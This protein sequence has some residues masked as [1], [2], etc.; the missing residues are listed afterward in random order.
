MGIFG[1]DDTANKA[2][3]LSLLKRQQK[4]G[5]VIDSFNPGRS[6]GDRVFARISE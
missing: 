4:Q 3:G 6:D 1:Q 5:I 2:F